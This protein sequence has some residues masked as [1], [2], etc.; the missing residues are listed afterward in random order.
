MKKDHVGDTNKLTKTLLSESELL[1]V[2]QTIALSS[3]VD[4]G[5]FEQVTLNASE[6]DC[7]LDPGAVL[8]C[9]GLEFPR[10]AALVVRHSRK[11]VSLVEVLEDRAEYLR[12]LV[13]ESNALGRRVHVRI[14]EGMSEERTGAEDVFVGS[15][16]SLFGADDEGD[17][18]GGEIAIRTINKRNK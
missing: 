15:K 5:I 18:V 6:I 12:L 7:A 8:V 13:R 17:N 4:D 11:V 10:V 16:E 3:A 14:S 2:R 1:Q 9:G